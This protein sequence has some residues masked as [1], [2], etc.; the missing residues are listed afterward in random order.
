VSVRV[1]DKDNGYKKLRAT[2]KDA[3]K[4]GGVSVGV[5]ADEGAEQHKSD[6]PGAAPVTVLDVAIWNEFGLGVPARPFL[7]NW[8][9]QADSANR[10]ALRKAM[11]LV[12]TG[13]MT[14]QQ[15]LDLVGLK[16]AGGLQKAIAGQTLG[17][18]ANAPETIARKGSSTPLIKD[19]QLRQS[20][21]HLVRDKPPT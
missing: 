13:K 5:H 10:E 3:S 16:F 2:L 9:A 1:K 11:R 18:L 7:S 14:L 20:I 15:A 17:L 12:V 8:Y 4:G 19:G 6:E 21:T